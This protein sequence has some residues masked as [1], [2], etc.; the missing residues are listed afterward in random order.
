LPSRNSCPD[1]HQPWSRR[2]SKNWEGAAQETLT[3]ES[4]NLRPEPRAPNAYEIEIFG[5][6]G[7]ILSLCGGG[8]A[9]NAKTHAVGVGF[10]QLTM[11][12]GTG[13]EPV[14]FRL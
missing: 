12:A 5:Q 3:I 13:F 7:A 6:L 8:L 10:K 1:L 4:I 2:S 14:T 11:V 9:A